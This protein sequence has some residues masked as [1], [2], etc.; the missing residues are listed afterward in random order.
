MLLKTASHSGGHTYGAGDMGDIIE[1][2]VASVPGLR[3]TSSHCPVA[4]FITRTSFCV[5]PAVRLAPVG[6][7]GMLLSNSVQC[8]PKALNLVPKAL[9]LEVRHIYPLKVSVCPAPPHSHFS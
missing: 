1:R 9:G 7:L 5:T 2:R 3:P 6:V 4:I 8:I